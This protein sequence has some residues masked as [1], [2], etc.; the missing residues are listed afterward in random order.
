MD[1]RVG[2]RRCD[3]G[4]RG[5]LLATSVP[6]DRWWL[7]H[8]TCDVDAVRLAGDASPRTTNSPRC[9][10]LVRRLTGGGRGRVATRRSASR[11]CAHPSD[12]RP[13]HA[14]TPLTRH[15]STGAV[16]PNGNVPPSIWITKPLVSGVVTFPMGTSRITSRPTKP[17]VDACEV[18][19]WSWGE[20]N[21]RPSANGSSCYDHSRPGTDAVPPAGRL[22]VGYPAALAP[23]LRSVSRL[24]GGQLTFE[25]SSPASV[26]GLRWIGP[27]RH[28]WSRCLS[29]T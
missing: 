6:A 14:R 16:R 26:A 1:R 8:E 12:F 23:S 29:T 17:L 4:S 22:A 19:W 2:R 20:S 28:C 27:V 10:S 7:P 21:P 13:C 18:G 5:T 3:S 15:S 9:T 11:P 25:R 24:C